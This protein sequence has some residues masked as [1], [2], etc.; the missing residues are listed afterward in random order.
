MDLKPPTGCVVRS[1]TSQMYPTDE[2]SGQVDIRSD[3]LPLDEAL[4]QV[5]IRSDV[6]PR[7]RLQVRSTSGQ[8]YP[9]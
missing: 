8:M 2:A 9:P 1:E 4:G 6:P 3:V 5:N 7:I